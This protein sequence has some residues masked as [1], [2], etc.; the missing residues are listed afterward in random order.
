MME[1]LTLLSH[2]EDPDLS[3]ADLRRLQTE[4]ETRPLET[5]HSSCPDLTTFTDLKEL[6]LKVDSRAA[7]GAPAGIRVVEHDRLCCSAADGCVLTGRSGASLLG[8][9]FAT[10][11]SWFTG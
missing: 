7:S 9:E 2:P 10:T 8:M 5:N 11:P 3:H 6:G 1:V 4:P